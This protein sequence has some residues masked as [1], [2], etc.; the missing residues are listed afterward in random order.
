MKT[1]NVE[2]I[3]SPVAVTP[4]GWSNRFKRGVWLL[5]MAIVGPA[6][7]LLHRAFVL[8]SDLFSVLI[9]LQVAVIAGC[10]WYLFVRRPALVRE[11]PMSARENW[12]CGA[13]VAIAV[14]LAVAFLLTTWHDHKAREA[15]RLRTSFVD[16]HVR[17]RWNERDLR[18]AVHVD[19][20]RATR[21]FVLNAA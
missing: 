9:G 20:D 8:P 17:H 2:T 1:L 19:H 18:R 12:L 5:C 21:T 3:P 15:A 14:A 13:L 11:P 7:Q 16:L 6:V 4:S 10:A